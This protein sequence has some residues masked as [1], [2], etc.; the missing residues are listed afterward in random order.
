MGYKCMIPT[1]ITLCFEGIGSIPP[2]QNVA[3]NPNWWRKR[4]ANVQGDGKRQA[5]LSLVFRILQLIRQEPQHTRNVGMSQIDVIE[6]VRSTKDE[7]CHKNLDVRQPYR[8][9]GSHPCVS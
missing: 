8:Y 3:Y 9:P 2:T 1:E 7:H 6:Q 5:S 4:S